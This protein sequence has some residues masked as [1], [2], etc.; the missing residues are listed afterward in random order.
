MQEIICH[1]YLSQVPVIY[2]KFE[3]ICTTSINIGKPSFFL[4]SR[5]KNDD[6]RHGEYI[7]F[8]DNIAFTMKGKRL[9]NN[10]EE[11]TIDSVRSDPYVTVKVWF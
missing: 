7:M 2:R 8:S 10:G 4:A 9:M 11:I 6:I 3:D 5:D 1:T